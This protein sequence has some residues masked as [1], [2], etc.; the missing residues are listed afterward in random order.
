MKMKLHGILSSLTILV[1]LSSIIDSLKCARKLEGIT[2]PSLPLEG[3]FWI[4]VTNV[5]R[6]EVVDKYMPNTKYN[7]TIES[8]ETS[9]EG[10]QAFTRFLLTVENKNDSL[11]AGTLDLADE[12]L[13]QFSDKCPSAVIESSQIPKADISVYWTSPPEGS[14][15]VII[16]ATIAENADTWFT[17]EG[18]LEKIICQD[19]KAIEDDPGPVLLECKACDEAKYEVT[20]EGLWSRNTHPKDFP[21]KGWLT[22][23]SDVIGASHTVNY[24]FWEQGE[25]AS[26]GLRQVAECGSTRK[27]ESELK[28]KS[29]KIRTIIKA[30]GI[31]YPNVTGRTFAVFRVDNKH[32]LMSLVSMI[33]PSPDWIVGVSGLELCLANGSWI[34]HKELNLYPY[35]AGTDSGITYT[36]ADA[37][38]DPAEPI[39]LITTLYPNDSRSPFY[40][41]SGLDMKPLAKLYLNRQRLYEKTCDESPEPDSNA[42]SLVEEKPRRRR[43]KACKVTHWGAWGPCP[44]NCGGQQLRQRKYRDPAAAATHNCT[45]SLTDRRPC[46]STACLS[47]SVIAPELDK[48]ECELTEWGSWSECSTSCGDGERV[49]SRNFRHKKHRKHCRAVPHGP[50]LQQSSPCSNEPCLDPEYNK[51]VTSNEEK[52]EEN[53]DGSEENVTGEDEEIIEDGSGD[54]PEAPRTLEVTAK[55]LQKCPPELYHQWSI[56]A[57]CSASCGTGWAI[58]TRIPI[59]E[60]F[61]APD[62][63]KT[64]DMICSATII[65]CNM[66]QQEAIEICN[67]PRDAGDCNGRYKRAYYDPTTQQCHIFDWSGCNG[68]RNRFDTLK[69]CNDMCVE[70]E[71][72]SMKNYK[73]S[74]SSVLSYHI[75]VQ[76]QQTSKT[77]RDECDSVQAPKEKV[78]CKV[79]QW[80][81]WSRC[82]GCHGYTFRT[83]KILKH[84]LN[85]GKRCPTKLIRKRKCRKIVAECSDHDRIKRRNLCNSKSPL[86]QSRCKRL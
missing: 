26:P 17:S 35:D 27:L 85:G 6:T 25:L 41:P 81:K 34:E 15:C 16:R 13:T 84:A 19:P 20:F 46:P 43:N 51:N 72:S 14:G 82:Y 39:R 77:K 1:C 7:V 11:S 62:E 61:Q 32:H 30:R 21:S 57:P 79:T 5:N 8:K 28:G 3:R 52:E 59:D 78:D 75:P 31:T 44:A 58:R 18:G 4:T 83:R 65:D 42:G 37:P 12:L 71:R 29:D 50:Q 49:R 74:I 10:S 68:T 55:W 69:A 23:F 2:T 33:D 63:C 36:S 45:E 24:S 66:T 60:N 53:D 38:T 56:W 40:D 22:R 67:E 47:R 64:Q 73:V 48:P 80:G 9:P 54:D 70:K 86:D 76:G